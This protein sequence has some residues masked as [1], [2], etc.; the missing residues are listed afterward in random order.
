MN[1]ARFTLRVHPLIVKKL[2]VI[3]D[4]NGRS[5]NK[6]IEQILKWVIEDFENKCGK[7]RFEE[8]ESVEKN[9]GKTAVTPTP[10]NNINMDMLFKM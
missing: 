6:E 8:I 9:R 5:V 7:I 2:K 10:E 1:Q 4:H 3:A